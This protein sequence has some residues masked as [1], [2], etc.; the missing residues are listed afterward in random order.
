MF[1]ILRDLFFRKNSEPEQN[2]L[3]PKLR[4]SLT[5]NIKLFQEIF[6]ADET[7]SYRYFET[8]GNIKC[9]IIYARGMINKKIVNRDLLR[10]CMNSDLLRNLPLSQLIKTLQE[11]VIDMGEVNIVDNIDSIVDNILYGDTLL[12][13]DGVAQGILVNSKG[14]TIRSISEPKTEGVVRGPREGFIE[15]LMV[16]TSLLRRRIKNP[17]LKFKFREL[18]QRTKTKICICY[19]K[20]LTP[21]SIL[22]ELE[23]RLK[24]ID[25]DG[26]LESGYIEEFIRDSPFS[27]FQTVGSTER[28]DVVA[29]KLLEGRVAILC[30]GTP[31]ALTVP[32][33][34]IEK[35]QANED[36]YKNFY[37]ASLDRILRYVAYFL[38]TST[39]AIYVALITFHQEMIPTSLLLSIAASREGVPFPTIIEAIILGLFFELLRE[40]G[41]RLPTVIG[42]A[43]SI[44]GAI[45]LGEA[46]VTAKLASSPMIVVTALTGIASFLVP[47]SLGSI[48]II[49]LIL[50]LLA[51]FL[52]LYGFMFGVIGMF[53][54]LMS[55]RSFGVPFMSSMGSISLQD[56][57]DNMI[58]APW[59]YMYLRPKILGRRN[60]QRQPAKK[61][62]R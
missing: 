46:A 13:A 6:F 10:P 49:R 22:E 44:V 36:Y 39:P 11:K 37:Y 38:T 54:H 12:L 20:G 56:L 61:L 50:I 18:G 27:P 8:R 28:P 3:S 30:D 23:A 35:F 53:I 43:V 45:I 19:I 59:W 4:K 42:E 48:I 55:I 26:I 1:K 58:R 62:R 40:G 41:T 21:E 60:R 2:A 51:A 25:I 47:Q 32:F 7:I 17:D 52:G 16:N 24:K 33:L 5:Q 57:K 34:F 15:C 14:W 31:F 29:G 9:C